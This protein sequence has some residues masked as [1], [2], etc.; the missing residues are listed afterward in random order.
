MPNYAT[1]IKTYRK[2]LAET[3]TPMQLVKAMY[4]RL[5]FSVHNARDFL[6]QNDTSRAHESLV[7]AQ[8]I[9]EELDNALDMD[10]GGELA[11]NLRRLYDFLR[12]RLIYANITKSPHV[13]EE[14]AP[15]VEAMQEMWGLV[16]S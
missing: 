8:R 15:V 12:Q 10:R 7:T 11:V 14:I 6:A 9:V 2:S 1:A 5:V 4:D 13:V 3:M 16:P